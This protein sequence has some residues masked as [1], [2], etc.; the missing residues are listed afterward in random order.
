V[1]GHLTIFLTRTRGPFWSIRPARILLG[2][3]IGTQIIATFIAVYGFLMTPLGWKWAGFVWAYAI[4]WFLINDQIKWL[5]YR[6][7]DPVKKSKKGELD[8]DGKTKNKAEFMPENKAEPKPEDKTKADTKADVKPENKTELKPEDKANPITQAEPKPD[9]KTESKPE[10]VGHSDEKVGQNFIHVHMGRDE[11]DIYVAGP[12]HS[13]HGFAE[14]K[15]ASKP[16]AKMDH[17][18]SDL[19]LQIAKRAYELYEQRGRK[20]GYAE[21]DWVQAEREIRKDHPHK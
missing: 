17:T 14:N 12:G 5:A 1:A 10:V 16:D 11:L 19:N 2:A 13:G 21:Q 18:T 3:V 7:F 6:I 4:V 8:P 9:A 20:E 15:D